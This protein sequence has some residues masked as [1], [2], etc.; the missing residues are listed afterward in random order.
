MKNREYEINYR[1]IYLKVSAKTSVVK[2][3]LH[4][5]WFWKWRWIE[6]C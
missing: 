1:V 5:F 6:L 4:I 2:I 3:Y